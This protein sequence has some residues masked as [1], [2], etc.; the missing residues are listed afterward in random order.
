M[1]LILHIAI[2]LSSVAFTT[3]LWVRPSEAKLKGSYALI[4]MTLVSGTYL[5]INSGTN[6]IRACTTGLLYVS[7]TSLAVAAVRRKLAGEN[8]D[9]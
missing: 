4:V 7:A 1:I 6:M 9:V 5:V 8:T 2:A 3:Y